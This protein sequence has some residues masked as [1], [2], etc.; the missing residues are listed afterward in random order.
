ML[1]P[2]QI[3]EQSKPSLNI[4]DMAFKEIEV[5]ERRNPKQ[6]KLTTI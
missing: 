4:L 2:I 6:Q 3:E 5:A 1:L